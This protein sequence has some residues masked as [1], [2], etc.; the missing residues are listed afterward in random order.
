M[1]EA[2]S[3]NVGVVNQIACRSR[4]ANG[5]IEHR[6]V[7]SR[8]SEQNER[9]RGQHSLQIGQRDLRRDWRMKDPGDG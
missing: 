2:Q 4:L 8:F 6:R 7:P 5:P 9:G 3:C 1:L